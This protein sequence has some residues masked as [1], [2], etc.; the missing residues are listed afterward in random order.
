M[1]AKGYFA[2]V[3]PSGA[4]PWTWFKAVNY[5]Y[6][7]AGENL[8]QGFW[9]DQGLNTAWMNSP[10]HRANILNSVYTKVGI[11]IALGT[12]EGRATVFVAEEFA[13]PYVTQAVAKAPTGTMV[14]KALASKPAAVSPV[15]KKRV[16]VAP[17]KSAVKKIAVKR[18]PLKRAPIAAVLPKRSALTRTLAV[19]K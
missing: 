3:S 16:A 1:A 13:N 7:D 17:R 15:A 5:Y 8:A 18:A 2:H 10:T 6:Y 12:Y 11:G 19:A 14:A 9:D 4:T